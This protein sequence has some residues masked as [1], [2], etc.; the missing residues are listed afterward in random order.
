MT[1]YGI[2]HGNDGACLH[3]HSFLGPVTDI[4]SHELWRFG[5][6][7]LEGVIGQHI[8]ICTSRTEHVRSLFPTVLATVGY[9]ATGEGVGWHLASFSQLNLSI[10]HINLPV[11]AHH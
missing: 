2:L 8:H 3:F 10:L 11:L 7:G 6:L 4:S 9:L 1:H 5:W